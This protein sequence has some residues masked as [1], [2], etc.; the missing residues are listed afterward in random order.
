MQI[1]TEMRILRLSQW[2]YRRF[3]SSGMLCSA[4]LWICFTFSPE[5][6]SRLRKFWPARQAPSQVT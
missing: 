4:M 3:K 2:C 1:S 6:R 5:L